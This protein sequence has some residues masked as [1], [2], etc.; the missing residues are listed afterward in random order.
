MLAVGTSDTSLR[1]VRRQFNDQLIAAFAHG[2][3]AEMLQWNAR[4]YFQAFFLSVSF[5]Y[6]LPATVG[7]FLLGFYAGRRR[8]LHDVAANLP[9]FRKLFWWSLPV[10]LVGSGLF[11]VGTELQRAAIIDPL[12][13]WRFLLIL[14]TEIGSLA[15]CLFYVAALTLLYQHSAW[16]R[17]L[18]LLAPLG[19]MALTNYL[20]QSIICTLFFFGY[21]DTTR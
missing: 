14:P 3:Y 15:L 18:S 2:G 16:Q 10:G 5:L 6:I 12:S 21:G 20:M 4:L 11:L 8:L 17:R 19:R 1:D 9:F 13:L 7:R